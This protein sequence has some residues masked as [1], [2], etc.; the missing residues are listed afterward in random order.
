MVQIEEKARKAKVFC[1]NPRCE[2]VPLAYRGDR[3]QVVLTGCPGC[4]W[5][6]YCSVSLPAFGLFHVKSL[7]AEIRTSVQ[8]MMPTVTKLNVSWRTT[9]SRMMNTGPRRKASARALEG[10]TE[11]LASFAKRGE[12]Y[13]KGKNQR[14]V[15]RQ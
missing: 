11:R 14:K 10:A 13:R 2:D 4:H 8:L 5:T 9:L 7:T 12:R 3:T 15:S 1:A 6:K